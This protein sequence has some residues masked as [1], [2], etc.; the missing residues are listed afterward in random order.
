MSRVA[1]ATIGLM[2]ATIIAKIFGFTRELVLASSYGASLYSDAYLIAM[3]IPLV[4]FSIIGAALGTI[5]VPMYFDINNKLGKEQSLKFTNNILNI[6]LVI[7]ISLALVGFIFTKPLVRLFAI[8][9]NDQTLEITVKFTKILILG[10]VFT[11]MSYVMTYY[12]N[13]NNNFKV[14]GLMSLPKNIIII[15]SIV[16]SIKYG[17]NIL[18]WGSLLGV[19]SE[20]LFQLPFA[21]KYDYKYTPYINI[22]DEYIKKSIVLL[23]PV[24]IGVCVNQINSMIDR[25][26]ASTL[27]EGSISALNYANKLNGF[28]MALFITSI[29]S[30]IYPMFSRLS[31]QNNDKEFKDAIVKSVNSVII[32]VMPISVGAIVLADPIVKLLFQRGEFDSRATSMTAVALAMYAIGMVAFGLRDVL[33]KV[34]YS[35]QDTKTPMVNGTIAMSINILLNFMLIKKFNHAGLAFATSISAIIC[36]FLFFYKLYKKIGDFDQDKIINTTIKSIISAVIM[37]CITYFV[38]SLLENILGNGFINESLALCSS[39]MIGAVA[40]GCMIIMLKVEEINL[41]RDMLKKKLKKCN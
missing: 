26:L 20:F 38:Y 23:G 12:L 40:Y 3:N 11:G 8:G 28:V 10:I 37:G 35:L 27:T 14:P 21:M 6:V 25:T 4:I 18:I 7:C 15:V 30:V 39:I 36:I 41:I 33:G 1:K 22:K 9:F 2:C 29:I 16:L 34:F 19:A 5:F 32:L 31:S 17:I 24:I 13:V